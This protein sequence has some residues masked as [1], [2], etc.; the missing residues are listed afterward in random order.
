[1]ETEFS[2]AWRSAASRVAMDIRGRVG[3]MMTLCR[4][5]E[6]AILDVIGGAIGL[7]GVAAAACSGKKS[8]ASVLAP[9][10][11][12][13]NLWNSLRH[14]STCAQLCPRPLPSVREICTRVLNDSMLRHVITRVDSRYVYF[15]SIVTKASLSVLMPNSEAMCTALAKPRRETPTI[16]G[17]DSESASS[18]MAEQ[19][20][21]RAHHVDSNMGRTCSF[22]REVK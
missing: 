19:A 4:V 8:A 17:V 12:I 5:D 20:A 6:A 9:V 21:R 16:A 1:M 13:C 10:P 11:I 3:W 15:A 18:M 7:V 14:L 22:V 2:L